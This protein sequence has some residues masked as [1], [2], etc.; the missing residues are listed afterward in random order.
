MESIDN[1]RERIEALE[2]QMKVMGAHTRTVA[3]RGFACGVGLRCRPCI[4]NSLIWSLAALFMLL[5][6]GVSRVAAEPTITWTPRQVVETVVQGGTKTTM[7]SFTSSEDLADIAADITPALQPYVRATPSVFPS[8]RAG[9]MVTITLTLS[10]PA[11]APLATVHGTLQLR[12]TTKRYHTFAEPLPITLTILPAPSLQPAWVEQGP[13]PIFGGQVVVPPDNAVAGAINAIVTSPTDPDLVYVGAVNG[14]IWQTS[15]ATTA[16]PTWTPLTDQQLP[17]LSIR[18]LAMSP[19][20]SNTLFA[21]T[22]STSSFAFDGSPGFGVARSLDGG[23]TWTV[24]AASTLARRRITSIV[25]TPLDGGNVV[26]AATQF[27]LVGGGG[28]FRSIDMGSSFTRLSGDGSSGLPD[29]A[30]SSLV[31]DPSNPSRFYAAVPGFFSPTVYR[32]DDGGVTWTSMSTGLTG[33]SVRILLS[34]HNNSRLG[35]NVIYAM[36]IATNGH[37]QGVFRSD[38]GGVTWIALASP[39]DVLSSGQG[40]FHG[41]IVADPMD[42]NVVFIAGDVGGVVRGEVAQPPLVTW[43]SVVGF[44][45]HNTVPHADSRAM[46][47]DA[48]GDILLACDGGLFRLVDPNDEA[49]ERRWVSVNGD[50]GTAEFHSVAYDPLSHIVFGGTQ[51]NGTPIQVA[52]GEFPWLQLLGGDGGNVAVDSDQTAHPGTTI[53]YTS[54]QR[55]GFFNR[56]TWDAANTRVSGFTVVR[57]LITSGPGTGQTLSQFDSVQFYQP[58]VLNAIDPSRMLIGTANLYESLDQGDSLANLGFTGFIGNGVGASPLAYGGRLNGEPHADVFYVGAGGSI[59]HRVNIG[60]L[61][62]TLSAYPGNGSRAL[63]MD[64][65]NYQSIYVVDAVSQVWASFDEGA[66]WS[67]LTANLPSLSSDIRAVEVV[68]PDG[69]AAHAVVLVGGLGGVFQLPG[70]GSSGASWTILSRELPHGLVLDLHYNIA[71]DVLVAGLLGRGAWT[72]TGF[73]EGTST[74]LVAYHGAKS[75]P[76]EAAMQGFGLDLPVM[77]PEAAPPLVGLPEE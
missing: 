60:D 51:D 30:V 16:S 66:S 52:P 32:S 57:L 74:A 58:F 14:G 22:G 77:L 41:A 13:G 43:Q 45:A 59:Q 7:V 29:A 71:N 54:F 5:L 6:S 25:P 65:Q 47:F 50:I 44:G 4:W 70:S 63:V 19:V 2:Q 10:A 9:K 67:N 46:V 35:T 18:S 24:L 33:L 1:G 75:Q 39:P 72:L 12:K 15:N 48:N 69:T 3:R 62:T 38:N 64:P 21:G 73:F 17:A 11:D 28:V 40:V 27:D 76:H 53:R 36:I 55:F 42:P 68:S 26:L 37:L 34:V 31:A 20:D 61:M 49:G 23:A 56:T 8:L